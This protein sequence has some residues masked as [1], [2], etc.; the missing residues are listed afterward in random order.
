MR[1]RNDRRGFNSDYR[2]LS[3]DPRE[4]DRLWLGMNVTDNA[5]IRR[6]F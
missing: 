1:P 3:A 5:A 2:A 6:F 4:L